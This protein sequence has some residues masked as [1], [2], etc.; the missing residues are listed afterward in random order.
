ML[1]VQ[2]FDTE[3]S[4]SEKMNLPSSVLVKNR[5]DQTD[6]IYLRIKEGFDLSGQSFLDFLKLAH[7][8]FPKG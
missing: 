4:M 2:K 6:R 8:A 3:E 7:K 5:N 1:G